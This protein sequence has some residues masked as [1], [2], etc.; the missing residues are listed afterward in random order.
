MRTTESNHPSA[1]T[2]STSGKPLSMVIIFEDLRARLRMQNAFWML[3]R[4]LSKEYEFEC[5]WF[6]FDELKISRVAARA[7]VAAAA[8]DLILFSVNVETVPPKSVKMWIESWIELKATQD[9]ALAALL[10]KARR[11]D[12]HKMPVWKYFNHIAQRAGMSFLPEVVASKQLC[13]EAA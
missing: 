6:G 11:P 10:N 9:A 12:S 8:A 1:E 13:D 2:S 5:F 3:T 4:K 7:R